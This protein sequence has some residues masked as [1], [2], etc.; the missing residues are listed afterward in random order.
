MLDNT[1][2]NVL[3]FDAE[4]VTPL[5]VNAINAKDDGHLY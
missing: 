3:D 4:M 2:N 5:F 1:S